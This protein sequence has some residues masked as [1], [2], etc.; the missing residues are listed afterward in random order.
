MVSTYLVRTPSAVLAEKPLAVRE[1]FQSEAGVPYLTDL[2]SYYHVRLVEND[3]AY[4]SLGD[5]ELSDGSV[6]DSLRFYPEGRSADYPPGIVFMTEL[7]WRVQ[8]LF[9]QKSLELTEFSLPVLMSALTALAAYIFGCRLGGAACGLTAG[10][11]VGCGPLFASRTLYGRFD[12]DMFTLG[13]E[14]LMVLFFTE[15]M[16]GR[17]REKR[18]ENALAFALTVWALGKCWMPKYSMLFAGLTIAGGL[19]WA[20]TVRALDKLNGE[21]A[22]KK[23]RAGDKTLPTEWSVLL[24][25]A[26]LT[27]LAMLLSAGVS[28]FG[29]VL[30]ALSFTNAQK[31]GEGVLPSLYVSVSELRSAKFV[32]GSVV[33]FFA[34]YNKGS[35]P[36]VVSGVG[37]GAAFL[38]AVAALVLL[39]LFSFVRFRGERDDLPPARDCALYFFEL[40]LWM[41]AGLVLCRSG[42]RFIFHLSLPVALLAGF[43]I[44][45]VFRRAGAKY[46]RS[47]SRKDGAETESDEDARG[48][49]EDAPRRRP[50]LVRALSVVLAALLFILA[51]VPAMVGATFYSADNTPSVSDASARAMEWIHEHAADERAVV[52]SWWDMGYYY[53]YAS[54]HPCLWDGG[55]QD[56]VRAIL[57]ARALTADD[58]E[59]SRGIL[60]MLSGS[61][62]AAVEYLSRHTDIETEFE[63]LWAALPMESGAARACL[64][65]RCGLSAEEADEAERLIHPEHAKET[66][67]VLTLTMTKQI[68]WY[69]YFANWDFTGTQNVP[70]STWYSR[71]PDGTSVFEE[72]AGQDYLENVRS[73]ETIWRLFFNA[74]KNECFTPMYEWHDGLEHVRV[75]RVEL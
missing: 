61:G 54:G 49:S 44:S 16:R 23:R 34:A 14:L 58:L 10:L 20:L 47:A 11:L 15:A 1:I 43:A 37:G 31:A 33:D 55:S 32:F 7:V 72:G 12:T 25:C 68:G 75:W 35:A 18:I 3:L 45:R 4:G 9:G 29:Q 2:D 5:A 63:A 70:A 42:V 22:V 17:S 65:E 74:E 36:T 59:L 30:S 52:A 67:L 38:L 56:S 24:G 50:I 19:L 57:V 41:A 62:N 27:A 60:R 13:L 28:V 6:W 8:N 73:K 46:R 53:E 71:M 40:L 51:V 39:G 66:Y 48:V 69:E 64:C 21:T 26:A